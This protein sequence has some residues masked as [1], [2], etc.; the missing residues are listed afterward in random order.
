[1]TDFSQLLENIPEYREYLGVDEANSNFDRVAKE[2]PEDAKLLDLGKSGG[3][4]PIRCLKIGDGKHN[5]LIYGFPNPE[6]P[7]GGVLL[8]YMA[9]QFLK[10]R[11]LLREM[12]FTWYAIACI[13]PDG[14]RLNNGFLKGPLTPLNFAKNYYRTPTTL[15]GEENFPFRYGDLDFHHPLPETKALMRLLDSIR[16][17]MIVSL[18]NMKWGGVTYQVS[19]PCPELYPT[20]QNLTKTFRLE[21]RKRLGTMLAPAVQLAEYFTPVRNYVRAKGAGKG[22]LQELTGAF[23]YEY[24]L[25]SNPDVFMIVPE[26]CLWHDP[27]CWDDRLS[28]SSMTD[29]LRYSSQ[30]GTETNKFMLSMFDKVE[31]YLKDN[32]PFLNMIRPIMKEIRTPTVNVLDP[33]PELNKEKLQRPAT[34]AEKCETEGRAEI[35]RLFNLGAMIRMLDYQLSKGGQGESALRTSKTDAMS[36][37][38]E[39]NLALEKKYKCEHQPIRNLVGACLGSVLGSA[40]YVKWHLHRI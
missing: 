16:F 17:D 31:P 25:L 6:E 9:N 34:I 21:P 33:D 2:H 20:L 22:P 32:S 27:S 7:V 14:A 1:M 15:T 37:L 30:V 35:Y 10:N 26:C 3:G 11:S 13:D 4:E 19:E 24:T 28:E 40:E 12:D 5:A 38:D 18:H 39:W 23:V 8:D 36:K 29:A